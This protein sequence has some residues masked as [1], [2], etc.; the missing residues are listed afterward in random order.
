MCLVQI[1]RELGV[2]LLRPPFAFPPTPNLHPRAPHS[3][4]L[5]RLLLLLSPLARQQSS[6]KNVC[7]RLWGE[8]PPER[9]TELRSQSESLKLCCSSSADCEHTPR[10]P[11]RRV[12]PTPPLYRTRHVFLT[13][14]CTFPHHQ[15][16]GS[17]KESVR[18]AIKFLQGIGLPITCADLS[19][20][21]GG[22]RPRAHARTQAR[23]Q[24]QHHWAQRC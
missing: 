3:P 20:A 18:L 8:V 7:E 5:L 10:R 13:N 19:S 23:T 1:Q 24:Q 21:R 15:A 4:F 9:Q 6:V 12:I 16:P 17:P 11:G 22:P 2:C 14:T